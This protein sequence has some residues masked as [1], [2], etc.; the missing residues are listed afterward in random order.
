MDSDEDRGVS[1]KGGKE[2]LKAWELI[3]N[4]CCTKKGMGSLL[5]FPTNE[6]M[7]DSART[8]QQRHPYIHT[9]TGIHIGQFKS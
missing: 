5:G 8:K 3:C 9:D 4:G 2:T 6:V 1:A 7:E